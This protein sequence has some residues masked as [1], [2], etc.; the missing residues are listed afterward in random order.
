MM[1]SKYQ[2]KKDFLLWKMSNLISRNVYFG[3]LD[4]TKYSDFSEYEQFNESLDESKQIKP[5]AS[6]I[7]SI[8]ELNIEALDVEEMDEKVAGFLKY[9]QVVSDMDEE[10][11]SS[12]IEVSYLE[13]NVELKLVLT[14]E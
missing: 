8:L 6:L 1:K 3:K 7:D 10:F 9:V 13:K 12:Q 14:F 2:K 11:R 5:L 4:S